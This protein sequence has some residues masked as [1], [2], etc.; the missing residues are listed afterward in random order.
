MTVEQVAEWVREVDD[1][2][3]ALLR[4]AIEAEMGRRERKGASAPGVPRTARYAHREAPV[5]APRRVLKR[6]GADDFRAS[7]NRASLRSDPHPKCRGGM[8]S[9]SSLTIAKRFGYDALG[10][11][12]ISHSPRDHS[13]CP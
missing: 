7:I 1:R 5:P 12:E 3:L 11:N 13:G 10:F 9:Q 2:T 6:D 8:R 4:D